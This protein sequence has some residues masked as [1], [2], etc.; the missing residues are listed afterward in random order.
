MSTDEVRVDDGASRL[1]GRCTVDI[2]SGDVVG[3]CLLWRDRC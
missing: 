3:H 1:V 2:V